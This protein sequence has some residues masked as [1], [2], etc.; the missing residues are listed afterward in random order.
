MGEHWKIEAEAGGARSHDP[1]ARWPR[2]P[3]ITLVFLVVVLGIG[4]L[5]TPVPPEAPPP[6]DH[7]QE[8]YLEGRAPSGGP[9]A[10][11]A[12]GKLQQ[13]SARWLARRHGSLAEVYRGWEE[14]HRARGGDRAITLHLGHARALHAASS[15]RAHSPPLPPTARGRLHLDLVG[16][17]T[18]AHLEG[19][20]GGAELWLVDNRPGDPR[21]ALPGPGDTFLHLGRLTPDATGRVH[22]A[23]G[24]PDV[25]EGF[26]PDLAVVTAAGAQPHEAPW[27]WAARSYF[28]RLHT[29]LPRRADG[30]QA[31]LREALEQPAAVFGPAPAQAGSGDVLVAHELVSRQVAE[32]AELF[33]RETFDG[34]SR[35][36]GTCHRAER[37]LQVD[38]EFIAGLPPDDPLF[39]AEFDPQGVPGLE[40]PELLRGFGLVL[41]N[42]DGFEEPTEKFTLRGVP[43]I[44]SLATSVE[45]P[46]D[47]QRPALE[48][49][50]WSGDGAPLSGALR[51]FTVGAIVQHFPKSLERVEGRDFR[52][53]T[54]DELDALEAYMLT[55]GRLRD[56]RIT[57]MRLA[58]PRAEAGREAFLGQGECFVCHSNAGAVSGFGGNRNFETGI[59]KLPL[60]ARTLVDFP[61]DGGFG[62]EPLDRDGDGVAEAFGDG[63]FNTPPLVEAADT[64]P[65]FHNNALE[66]LEEAVAFYDGPEFAA[67][68]GSEFVDGIELTTEEI[69]QIA[70]FLRVLN[71]A[72]NLD[73]ARQRLGAAVLLRDSGLEAVRLSRMDPSD[74]QQPRGVRGVSDGLVRLA[75]VE[76]D[77]AVGVLAGG[78]LHPAE[79][80]RLEEVRGLLDQA[81]DT[82]PPRQRSAL[83]TQAE[84]ALAEVQGGLGENLVFVLG[85]GNLLF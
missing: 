62:R 31:T 7:R 2:G 84:V 78:D 25:G 3:K 72:Y 66:T 67:S 58:D 8:P 38:A 36:C 14:R 24:I 26:E 37:N 43:H 39:V 44:Q 75:R 50:G 35:T 55:V 15:P 47:D 85:E 22:L 21:G 74:F 70:A 13:S 51:F 81:L 12:D 42:I 65:F 57:G 23:M 83:L 40:I 49:T 82:D 61:D 27:L 20:P 45:A 34:N 54:E 63:T 68:P 16:G 79:V 32:G 76:L 56:T 11:G 33:F 30:H 41:E 18:E 59:A 48:R 10:S 77:D 46:P 71:A 80:S 73:L 4:I 6:E 17:T 53:P 5:G 19:L 1:F 52:L 28:E 29:R 69:E 60:L 9:G 64:A